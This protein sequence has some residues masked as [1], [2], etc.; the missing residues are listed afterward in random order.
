MEEA[1]GRKQGTDGERHRDS[2]ANREREMERKEREGRE[3]GREVGVVWGPNIV[4]AV[5]SHMSKFSQFSF[6]DFC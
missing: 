5:V 6:G 2:Q 1:R 4:S 3:G